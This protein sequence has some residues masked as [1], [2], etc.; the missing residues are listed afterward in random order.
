MAEH[1]DP[2]PIDL[3]E[4]S[5]VEHVAGRPVLAHASAVEQHEPVGVL[6]GKR[7][8][9]QRA[10]HRD[11]RLDAQCVHE[12]EDLLLVAEV[13]GSCGLVEEQH[14]RLLG[15][16]AGQDDPL[17]FTTR[18]VG[19]M[20]C[21]QVQQVESGQ[22]ILD[23][24]AILG[25]FRGEAAQVRIAA[26]RHVRPHVDALGDH[27]TL[28]Y[29]RDEAR[30]G[31]STP[32][33]W[34]EVVHP[35]RPGVRNKSCNRVQQRGL[36]SAIRSNQGHPGT[37]RNDEIDIMYDRT[38]TATYP[39]AFPDDSVH[40]TTRARRSTTRKNG[41]PTT[42]VTTPMGSSAGAMTVRARTSVK[43]RNA[44]PSTADTGTST[45]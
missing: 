30:H 43:T 33:P 4:Q 28:R 19:C 16:S 32:T 18:Q 24:P 44:A 11:A 45:R 17:E 38:P 25:A 13:E 9:V 31:T 3:R 20:T 15:D 6:R 10:E 14:P 23:D 12:I 22:G 2:S 37:G 42:A 26:E 1:F 21:G 41:A 39:H 36:A 40:A 34:V 29:Q 8:V 27:R 7:Q 5:G 35:K